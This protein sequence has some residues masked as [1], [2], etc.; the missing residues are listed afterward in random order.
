MTARLFLFFACL[1]SA[2]ACFAQSKPDSSC[3]SEHFEGNIEEKVFDKVNSPAYLREGSLNW[4]RFIEANFSSRIIEESVPDSVAFLK[5]SVILKFIVSKQGTISDIEVLYTWNT[6]ITHE[7][8]RVLKL[9]CG[10]WVP[11]IASSSIFLHAW[12]IEKFYF[13][14][15]RKN[16]PTF[17]VGIKS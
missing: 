7:A 10:N 12:H 16:G 11:A 9:S 17:K 8:I 1:F 15:D 13:I 2:A 5:D 4:N 6:S 3:Y 14:V